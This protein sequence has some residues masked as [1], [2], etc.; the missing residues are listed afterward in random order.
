MIAP[1]P[2][3]P[4][5]QAQLYYYDF[6]FE[7]SHESIPE[8]IVNH[9]AGCE[10]CQQQL[11]QLED[12]LSQPECHPDSEQAQIR[13][14][15]TSMLKL[16]FGY[17]DKPVT[18]EVARPFLPTLLDPALEIRIPTPVT[19]H[20]DHCQEC[21]EDL[22]T[23][24]KLNLNS[25][26]LCH[27]SQLF[28]E[29]PGE[30]KVACSQAQAATFAI[31]LMHFQET[32]KEVLKHLCICPNCRKGLYQYRDEF[33]KE[34]LRDGRVQEQVLC[35]HISSADIFDYAVPYGL[36]PANDQYAEFRQP[37]TSHVRI[38]PTCLGK[39]QQLHNTVYEIA[40]RPE[41][42]VVTIYHTD[43]STKTQAASES[44]SPYSGFPIRVEVVGHEDRLRPEQSASTISF[45]DALKQ[46]VSTLNLKS[47]TKAGLAAAAVILVAVA[48]FVKTPSAEAVT[49]DQIYKALERVANVYIASFVPDREEPTQEIW[50]SRTLNVYMMKTG[51]EV[52]LWDLQNRVR[53][54]KR[55][56]ANAVETTPLSGEETVRV[57]ERMAGSLGLLPFYDISEIPKDAK[58]SRVADDNLDVST[59]GTQLYHLM[60]VDQSYD[61]SAILKKWRVFVGAN[62]D[63][64]QRVE[65]YQKLTVDGD[66]TLMSVIVVEYLSDSQLRA[67]LDNIS[68]Q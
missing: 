49:I 31:V 40:E 10:H 51:N 44:D 64:P 53:K 37:L 28:A 47:W 20:L 2:D 43:E 41:S 1:N 18:C 61:G 54:M 22:E 65:R 39:M 9:I 56:E 3:S 67:I 58:W 13:S 60:W 52:V 26:Q 55:L 63:L 66:Y 14:A 36:D 16:H 62:T 25:K 30:D 59:E 5:R 33:Y 15:V 29:K 12:I 6:L 57:K 42:D 7:E 34:L 32:T 17:I 27:L 19:A 50:V 8:P 38:C 24:R 4:C 48:L 46:K 35:E 11:N 23:I 21:S 68:S 45:A